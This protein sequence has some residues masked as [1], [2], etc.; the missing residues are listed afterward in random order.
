MKIDFPEYI[1][2]HRKSEL[3]KI[4]DTIVETLPEKPKSND[5]PFFSTDSNQESSSYFII[6]LFTTTLAVQIRN[7]RKHYR[8]QYEIVRLKDAVDWIRLN[9]VEYDLVNPTVSSQLEIEFTTTDGATGELSATGERCR[10][11]MELYKTRFLP[12]F[13]AFAEIPQSE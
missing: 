6:W 4:I 5:T 7:S 2:D 11:L 9:A 13:A 12:N 3:R 10:A 8:V 1:E